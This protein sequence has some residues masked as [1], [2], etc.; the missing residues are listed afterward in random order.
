MALNVCIVDF[1]MANPVATQTSI[2]AGKC[3]P[4]KYVMTG[5]TKSYLSQKHK[6]LTK[7]CTFYFQ[8][9]EKTHTLKYN[10]F[11]MCL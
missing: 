8:F 1:A 5:Y 3:F 9:L 10:C 4:Y 2:P 6:I 11:S 7:A